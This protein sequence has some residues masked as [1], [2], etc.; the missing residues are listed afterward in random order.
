MADKLMAIDS[1][2][3]EAHATR[4]WSEYCEFKWEESQREF[5]L[6]MQ[7]SPDYAM[8]HGLYALNDLGGVERDVRSHAHTNPPSHPVFSSRTEKVFDHGRRISRTHL[9]YPCHPRNPG[10]PA[11]QEQ[12]CLD[13]GPSLVSSA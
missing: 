10:S 2:L 3:G 13:E 1:S 9:V 11:Q 7:L 4:G 8:A 6:A 12:T 5:Q